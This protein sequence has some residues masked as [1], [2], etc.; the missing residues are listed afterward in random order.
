M[1]RFRSGP[2]SFALGSP[3][4]PEGELKPHSGRRLLGLSFLAV[5]QV[6]EERLPV[7]RLDSTALEGRERE[8][9][10]QTRKF[11]SH[12]QPPNHFPGTRRHFNIS[13]LQ[14]DLVQAL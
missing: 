10:K 2:M 3:G 4:V 8:H 13:R 12:S 1:R 11:R 7:N 5:T 6:L 9:E 14:A